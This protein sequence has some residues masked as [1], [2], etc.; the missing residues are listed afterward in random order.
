MSEKTV[1]QEKPWLKHYGEGTPEHLDYEELI[2]PQFLERSAKN[3]PDN[4]ALKFKKYKITYSELDE[5]VNRFAAALHG[6]GIRKGDPVAILLPNLVPCVVAYYAAMKIGAITVMNNPLYTNAELKH[7]FNDSGAK[8]L[9]TLDLLVERMVD[10]RSETSIQQ[11]IYT[12]IGDYLRLPM[13]LGF[14]LVGKRKGLTTDVAPAENLYK[15]KEVLAANEPNVPE[16][17]ITFDDVA[18][19]QYTGGTTAVS[20]GVIL[21]HGNLS[22]QVQQVTQWF[23][24]FEDGTEDMLGALPFFHVFGLSTSM[25][26]SIY[27]GWSNILVPKPQAQDLLDTISTCKPSFAPL[28]PTMYIGMM[29]HPDLDK[30]DMSCLKGCFSGGAPLPLDVI[31]EFREKTGSLIVEG[32]GL[33]ESSPVTHVNPFVEGKDKAGSIGV[34][35]SD[36][37]CKIVD[38]DT[39]EL[40][41]QGK[42]G[43]LWVKGPQVMQGFWQLPEE[44]E[45]ALVDGWLRTGDVATMD[46]EGYFYI[47]DRLKDMVISGGYNVYPRDIDEVFFEHPKVVEACSIGIPHETRGE[48]IKVFIVLKEAETATSEEFLEYCQDKLAKYKWPVEIEMI[49]ELPKST[50]GKILRKELRKMELE[51]RQV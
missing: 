5:M 49:Q 19:Y 26:F 47:V 39:L 46:E 15:W 45:K 10:L 8:I 1:Y 44:T 22:R 28:V 30:T 9:I 38:P 25:N 4:A 51:K 27:K 24:V 31:K 21:T 2:L 43:E 40:V 18:M 50:V 34:P 13:K 41:E 14:R 33:T 17:D 3:F 12:S 11:I 7:Q 36:T 23:P 42:P 37:I 29:N 35:I 48:A 6:F 16:I 20:K 32:Y